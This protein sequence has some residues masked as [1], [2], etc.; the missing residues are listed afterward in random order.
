MVIMG[1]AV[2]MWLQG[3]YGKSLYLLDNLGVNLK[4]LLKIKPIK[5]TSLN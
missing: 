4:L 2:H 3:V 1:E 5:R